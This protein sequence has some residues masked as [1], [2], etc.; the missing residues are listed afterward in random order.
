MIQNT[1][2]Y[3]KYHETS[4][5]GDT[6]GGENM[7]REPVEIMCINWANKILPVLV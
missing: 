4:W 1:A 6:P 2:A 3:K 7:A 5:M